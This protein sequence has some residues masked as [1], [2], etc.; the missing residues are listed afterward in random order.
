V[1]TVSRTDLGGDS[2]EFETSA[3]QVRG[4]TGSSQMS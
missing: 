2:L 4:E 3:T 1:G